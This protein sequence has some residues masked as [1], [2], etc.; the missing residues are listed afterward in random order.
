[1]LPERA[2]L[3]QLAEEYTIAIRGAQRLGFLVR[4]TELQ[5]QAVNALTDLK[6]KFRGFKT[7]AR[8]AGNEKA[9]NLIFHMQCGLNAMI[10]FLAMWIELKEGSHQRAWN[11][12]IDAQEYV[13]IALR[14]SD[15]GEGVQEFLEHLCGVEKVVFPGFSVYN[16]VGQVIRGG[17]CTICEQ[18]FNIC[19]HIEGKV[20]WGTLCVRAR[21]EIV[22]VDHVAI[23]DKPRDRRCIITEIT[24]EDGY[25]HDYITGKRTR[26]AEDKEEGVAGSF[27]GVILHNSS[28]EID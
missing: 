2:T 10:S 18:S 21:P 6:V 1:M 19:E 26:K 12:L 20:Y 13:S 23:V 25:Y 15:D 22:K 11:R 9:S 27:T 16:S 28:I 7:G 14:A 17:T 8:G 24:E 3:E 5:A 4:D